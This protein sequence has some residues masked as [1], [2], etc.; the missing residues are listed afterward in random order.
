MGPEALTAIKH[1]AW[2]ASLVFIPNSPSQIFEIGESVSRLVHTMND[3][4]LV[5]ISRDIKNTLQT[6]EKALDDL[7]TGRLS[8]ELAETLEE[9]RGLS[10]SLRHVIDPPEGGGLGQNLEASSGQLRQSLRRLD[11]LLGSSRGGLPE[12]LDNLRVITENLREMS[13]LLKN[14]PSQALFGRPPQAA[15]PGRAG[16]PENVTT[17]TLP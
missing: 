12:T 2:D 4:D 9:I 7:N 8:R 14:Q 11:Q 3:I 10:A 13:E 17:F 16:R 6:I 15:E 1:M 5:G